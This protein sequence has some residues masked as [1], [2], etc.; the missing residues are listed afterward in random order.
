MQQ[1]R[2]LGPFGRIGAAIIVG[3]ARL[4][5]R[6]RVEGIEHI[7]AAGSAIVAANHI[8]ALDGVVLGVVVWRYRRRLCRFLT[9]AEFFS[10]PVFGTALRAF[11]MIPLHRGERDAR[12]L[13]DAIG[14]LRAGAVAGIF[15]EGLVNPEPNGPL[16]R[17][18][19]GVARIALAAHADVVPVGISGTH[20]R[21]PRPGLRFSRPW[22]PV[23][24]FA[25]GRPVGLAGDPDSPEESRAAT[26]VVMSRIEPQVERARALAAR[27]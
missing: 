1:P 21:W 15:P 2:E 20:E 4:L 24:A 8:S 12:A 25:F 9:A 10:K 13:D 26:E 14:A 6:I 3:I 16:Q 18:R 11:R 19:S 5:F 22:R 17:G 27:R 7:P 23:V